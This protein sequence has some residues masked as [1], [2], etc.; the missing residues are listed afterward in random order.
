MS[1]LM[2]VPVCGLYQEFYQP[3]PESLI[4]IEKVSNSQGFL[5][6]NSLYWANILS[7]ATVE[8]IIKLAIAGLAR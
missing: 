3:I 2:I 4:H 8:H 5:D 1:Y 7:Q 6:A